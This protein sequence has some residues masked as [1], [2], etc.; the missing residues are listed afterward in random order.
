VCTGLQTAGYP[1]TQMHFLVSFTYCW[2]TY[3]TELYH[4]ELNLA[5]WIHVAEGFM[6][7][8]LSIST[9]VNSLANSL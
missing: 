1:T 3:W 4:S 5:L 9:A 2:G 7:E 8:S 6:V